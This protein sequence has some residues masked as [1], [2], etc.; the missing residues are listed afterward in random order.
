MGLPWSLIQRA[1]IAFF[2]QSTKSHK[3]FAEGWVKFGKVL[4]RSP[5]E[6]QISRQEGAP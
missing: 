1:D 4:A 6:T 5:Y 2:S 3:P